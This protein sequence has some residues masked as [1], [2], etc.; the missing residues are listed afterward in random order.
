MD[1]KPRKHNP[2]EYVHRDEREWETI[3]WPG[4][5]G[6]MLFHPSAD[7]PT[8]PNAGIVRYEPGSY[9]PQHE[10]D[11]AQV[12]YVLEGEFRIGGRVYGPGTMMY[13]PDPHFEQ[14]LFTETG[15]EMLFV[16]YQGPA[17]GGRPIYDGRF[18]MRARRPV[19]EEQTDI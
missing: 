10:H 12:W 5:T 1:Q 15:G 13:H 2:P 11:F 4:Q 9:H 14:D 6:K 17:T 16:Q 18:N 8:E 3:R 19:D 7:R